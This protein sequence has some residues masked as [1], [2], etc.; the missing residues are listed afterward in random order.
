MLVLM[1]L[2]V[3]ACHSSSS[4]SLIVIFHSLRRSA[5]TISRS[6]LL[7]TSRG[8]LTPFLCHFDF[9]RIV[10]C[11]IRSNSGLVVVVFSFVVGALNCR[12]QWAHFTG[13]LSFATGLLSFAAGL[14]RFLEKLGLK[15]AWF[16]PLCSLF[17]FM[18]TNCGPY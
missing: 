15:E 12:G 11:N 8:C 10:D 14:L 18:C 16:G 2:L 5:L 9:Y 4:T 7:L 3:S 13:R 1:A 17:Y 6:H